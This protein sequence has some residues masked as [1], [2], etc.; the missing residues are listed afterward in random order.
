[1]SREDNLKI[2]N[3]IINKVADG[4]D[5]HKAINMHKYKNG[6][7]NKSNSYYDG[8]GNLK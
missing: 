3:A 4:M 1:M 2:I 8:N 5:L 7:K 6:A